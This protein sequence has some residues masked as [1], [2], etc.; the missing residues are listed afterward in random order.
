MLFYFLNAQLFR[1]H[2]NLNT[3]RQIN[4]YCCNTLNIVICVS[5]ARLVQCK[6]LL[7][8]KYFYTKNPLQL[9]FARDFM[10]S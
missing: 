8:D 7:N 10:Y 3:R 6:A 1:L 9:N 2:C 4:E 5:A